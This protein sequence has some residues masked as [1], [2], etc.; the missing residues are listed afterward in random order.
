MGLFSPWFLA[1]LAA[2]GL[3]VY[4]HLL[5]KHKSTPLPF[6]SLMFF[7]PRTQ[8]SIQHRRL[9]Y[10]LLFTLRTLLLVLLALAFAG[11]FIMGG[12]VAAGG[13]NRLVVVAIDN[14][15]SMRQG[16]RLNQARDQALQVL[17]GLR[18][19][20][21]AQVL[22]FSRQVSVM[23][24]PSG[25]QAALR[26][27]VT[28][29]RPTDSRSSYGDLVRAL[30]SVAQSSQTPV[31]VHLFSDLQKS[32]MPAG[33]AELALPPG[34]S[35]KLHPVGDENTPN[36]AVEAVTAPARVDDKGRARVQATI[37]GLATE[38][39]TLPASLLLNGRS[40]ETK[41]VEVPAAGRATVEF[42]PLD[43]PHGAN[44]CEVRI[45]SK[46]AFAADDRFLFSVERSDPARV[47]FVHENRDTRSPTYF[48]AA[49]EAASQASFALDARTAFEL[50]GVNPASYAFVV[51]SNVT[52]I[53]GPFEEALKKRV[54]AGGA[55]LIALGPASAVRGRIPV[56]EGSVVESRYAA[57]QGERFQMVDWL[58][59]AHP[60]IQRANRWEGVKFYQLFSVET[61]NMRVLARVADQTPVL[62]ERQEGD[63]RILLFTSTLDNI[64]NDF[65]LH[66][67]FVPFVEQTARYLSGLDEGRSSMPVD[68][69]FELRRTSG[70]GSAADVLDPQGRRVLDLSGTAKA[71]GFTLAEE[72]FFEVR[73]SGGRR[74]LLAAN[75]DRRESN[76][77]TIPKE[78]LTL[79]QN[80]GEGSVAAQGA[81]AG[82]GSRPN[83]LWW[84][85]LFVALLLALAESSV[86][87]GYLSVKKEAA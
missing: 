4:F 70:E 19:D 87:A 10:L 81:V 57:R 84:Y 56:L 72:G 45:E 51:L 62:L 2:V 14:S 42:S 31:E 85:F 37:A 58:D 76:F 63:G 35:L 21:R 80:T 78:T 26:G 39:A 86:A 25:D 67:S 17:A 71:L 73:R 30:R 61:A 65:P 27:A 36:W 32:S 82:G 46:D 9:Q 23:A 68:S 33:F 59:T 6:S 15:F 53:P 29:I 7:E 74:E 1:G 75:A 5:R 20:D 8:S 34:A 83:P 13:G 18:P 22:A 11:P 60:S 12:P 47:L 52:G 79:W 38:A 64:A 50:T 77:E 16:N 41:T 40:V 54:R 43:P 28:A 66:S 24:E 55:V 3:P 49:L 48:R 69:F 44:R